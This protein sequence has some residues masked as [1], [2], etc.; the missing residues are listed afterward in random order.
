[1][2]ELKSCLCYRRVRS[3]CFVCTD[4]GRRLFLVVVLV[5]RPFE[6]YREPRACMAIRL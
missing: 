6:L 4:A 5:L 2:M 3:L 1:M